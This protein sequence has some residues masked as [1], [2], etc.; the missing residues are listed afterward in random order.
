MLAHSK[1]RTDLI[2]RWDNITRYKVSSHQCSAFCAHLKANFP[3]WSQN[4]FHYHLGLH[5]CPSMVRE[6]EWVSPTQLSL[7]TLSNWIKW[8]YIP[9]SEPD[10]NV[11]LMLRAKWLRP[12]STSNLITITKGMESFWLTSVMDHPWNSRWESISPNCKAPAHGV[13]VGGIMGW[14]LGVNHNV[15]HTLVI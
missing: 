12:E 14:M 11:K 8:H 1:I 6:R 15:L 10:I 3:L 9:T 7:S 2:D 4:H 5:V 13:E